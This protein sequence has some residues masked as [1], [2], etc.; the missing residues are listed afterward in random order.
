[1]HCGDL[2]EKEVQK[3]EHAYIYA[4]SPGGSHGKKS[5]CN[6]GVL[7]SIPG[8]SSSPGEG[9]SYPHFSILALRIPWTEEPGRLQSMG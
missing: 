5:A 1:M 7:G 8:S 3:G 2:K 9:N 6:T 4:G